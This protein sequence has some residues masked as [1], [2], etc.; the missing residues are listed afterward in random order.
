MSNL[1]KQLFILIAFI[2]S[3]CS[4]NPLSENNHLTGSPWGIVAGGAAGAGTASLLGATTKPALIASGI[5]GASVGYYL[6]TQRFA[7]AGL[8]QG[9]G[10]VFQLGDYVTIDIPSDSLFE[11]NTADL[12]PE[13]EPILKSVVNILERYPDQNIM[14]SGNTSGF[15]PARWEQKLSE[16]RAQ[17]VAAFLWAQ[18]IAYQADH[19]RKLNYVGYG[20]YF[21]IANHLKNDSI[22]QNSRIQITVYPTQDQLRIG[23]KACAFNNIGADDPD[24]VPEMNDQTYELAN[25][26]ADIAKAELP[27]HA[28]LPDDNESFWVDENTIS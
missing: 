12:L 10:Q 6:T 1:S 27:P 4:Y 21:P 2:L 23:K 19:L 13:A 26:D 15:S 24:L 7:A 5:G 28:I 25:K 9:G 14:I 16:N 17:R 18:G 22:R 11:P 3:S 20:N 8:I